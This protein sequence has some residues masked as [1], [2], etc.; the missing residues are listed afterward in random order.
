MVMLTWVLSL[1]MNN[2]HVLKMAQEELDRVVGNER[3]VNE[4]DVNNLM[5]LQ[6]IVKETFRLYPASP[7][8]I[9]R[10]FRKDCIIS[11]F[12]I[13]KDT[14]LFCNVWKLQRDPQ[15]WSSPLEFKPER[16]INCNK[17]IDVLG[18]DF[19]LIPF[20]AGRRMCPGTTAALQ[21]LHLI[22]ANLL[23]SFELSNVSNKELI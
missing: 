13:P 21:M 6:A 22:L 1:M 20:G 17:E 2:P 5:Y 16:F 12:H 18:R 15:I 7:L 23:H 4:S 3:K 11:D 14:W 9:Q 19:E 8:G 10:I